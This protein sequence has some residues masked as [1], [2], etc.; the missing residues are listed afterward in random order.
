MTPSAT[1]H[2][3]G[4]SG[5]ASGLI[6]ILLVGLAGAA[7][8]AQGW[9][10]RVTDVDVIRYVD[11]ASNLVSHGV[12]PAWG[13]VTRFGSYAPPGAAWLVAPGVAALRDMRL[14]EL[15]GSLALYGGTLLGVFLLARAT[16]GVTAARLAVAIYG[17]SQPALFLASTVWPRGH[18]FFYVWMAYWTLLWVRRR[19]PGYAAA[20]LATW[21][22]GMYVYLELAP[23][24]LM[25]PA[26][27]WLYRP[28]VRLRPLLVTGAAA[29]VLW[30]PYLHFERTREFVDLRSQLLLQRL[31]APRAQDNWCDPSLRLV[32]WTGDAAAPT[33]TAPPPAATVAIGRTGRHVLNV[34]RAWGTNLVANF[35]GS[36]PAS[37]TLLLGATLIGFFVFLRAPFAN[38]PLTSGGRPAHAGP[39]G[40][41]L[42]VLGAGLLG[43]ALLANEWVARR[44]FSADGTLAAHTVWT[45]RGFEASTGL[46]GLAILLRRR[47]QHAVGAL[48]VTVTP[49]DDDPRLLL[50][51]LAAPWIVL[52]LLT[53]P[54][55]QYRFMGLWSL[56][57]IVLAGLVASLR[58]PI[59]G[60]RLAVLAATTLTVALTWI[61]PFTA[62]RLDA[63]HR[64]GWAGVDAERIE[65]ADYLG[66]MLRAHDQDRA[67]IGYRLFGTGMPDAAYPS[68]DRRGKVG[69]VFDAILEYREHVTNTNRCI[70]GVSPHDQF[71]IVRR[72]PPSARESWFVGAPLPGGATR[73]RTFTT[74]AVD[75]LQ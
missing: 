67:A 46:A 12:V 48:H 69:G 65:V 37:G 68:V 7:I 35:Q 70:E 60:G 19:S 31:Q 8:A 25:L 57:V 26:A 55:V 58:S 36:I 59:T 49:P 72:S 44:Y 39:V 28:P 61:N 20:A 34:I 27:W 53:E 21:L 64:T 10:S 30:V 4:S 66:A 15:P 14:Y 6:L 47:V 62:T 74:F 50:A 3:T 51:A 73:L 33:A 29:F 42:T 2:T 40:A 1:R 38:S 54:G 43:G 45:I 18:P 63:W 17:L 11:A 24:V 16:F 41:W 71:R 32:R 56:Q 52:L 23:A 13:T 5:L 9:K 75:R 22:V